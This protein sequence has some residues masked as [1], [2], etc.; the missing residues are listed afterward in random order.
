[1]D[2]N[3]GLCILRRFIEA[4]K[5]VKW[6]QC[7]ALDSLRLKNGY[8]NIR[9]PG[10]SGTSILDKIVSDYV[11]KMGLIFDEFPVEVPDFKKIHAL[12]QSTD[13]NYR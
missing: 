3:R 8:D 13:I 11:F 1:M 12:L 5:A 2:P 10:G 6:K 4:R 9:P 7:E